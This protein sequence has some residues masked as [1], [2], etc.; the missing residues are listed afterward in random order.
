MRRPLAVLAAIMLAGCASLSPLP[1]R[2]EPLPG[3]TSSAQPDAA[4]LEAIADE[5]YVAVID[6]RGPDEDRGL[7][8][9]SAV[10][11]LGMRYVSL[12]VAN[13]SALTYEN[14]N[15]LDEILSGIDGPVLL[16]CSTG[17]RAGA[18]LAL[19]ERLNGA[20]AEDALAVGKAGGLTR[21]ELEATVEERLRSV[22]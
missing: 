11:S 14:A 15:A 7:D 17:N 6:L 5:G 20:S 8:E 12:P 4:A 10:E 16:H 22:E 1:N 3:I 13:A 2:T 9:Q 18:L 19:R 21:P